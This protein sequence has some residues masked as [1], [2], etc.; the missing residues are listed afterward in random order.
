[1][2]KRVNI[3]GIGDD[4]DEYWFECI[5]CEGAGTVTF[6]DGEEGE[7]PNCGGD[8]KYEGSAADVDS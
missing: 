6:P 3:D 8:G 1:M 2:P 5:D 4:P 7:C